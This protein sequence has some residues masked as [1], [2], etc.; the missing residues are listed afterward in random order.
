MAHHKQG[1]KT[2]CTTRE[3]AALLGVSLSTAQLWAE[4]GLLEAWKTGGGHRRISR[5]SIERLLA[6]PPTRHV[7]A[8]VTR[9]RRVTDV[10]QLNAKPPTP[11]NI[12]VVEDDAT[13]R[14]LYE[15]KLRGW[16][17][18]P[19]ISTAG[20]GYEALIRMGDSKPDLL[21]ADLQMPGMD[22]FRMLHTVST[23]PELAGLAI[24]VVS[25]LDMEEIIQRGGIP[26]GIPVL[27]KPVPFDR[28][29]AIA[30]RLAAER[31]TSG[32]TEQA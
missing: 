11:F 27:P 20:D 30:E 3:A 24:V 5:Q 21:I 22:G 15:I 28:L 13:L 29:R 16:P 4:S 12:L 17:M 2:F 1:P 19:R 26:E 25:G 7:P 6:N 14:R 10:A 32:D 23:A 9:K 31:Q 8:E 18:K